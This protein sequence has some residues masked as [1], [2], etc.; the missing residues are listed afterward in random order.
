[1]E[2]MLV[3]LAITIGLVLLDGFSATAGRDSRLSIRD[4]V[5]PWI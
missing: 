1:M 3:F 5:R 4:D 2:L